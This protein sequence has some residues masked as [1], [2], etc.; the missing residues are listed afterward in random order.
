MNK[1]HPSAKKSEEI[2]H[3]IDKIPSRFGRLMTLVVT[4]III[5]AIGLGWFISYPDIS[6][7][8]IS[9]NANT[10]KIN[11]VSNSSGKLKL[12]KPNQFEVQ[13]GSVVGFIENSAELSNI[14]LVDSILEDFDGTY[15]TICIVRKALPSKVSL[16]EL[17]PRYHTFI[18]S[19]QEYINYYTEGFYTKQEKTMLAMLG[20]QNLSLGLAQRR[21]A[22]TK[23]SLNISKR[24][25]SRDSILYKKSLTSITDFDR[26]RQNYLSDENVNQST[27]NEI[28]NVRQQIFNT[29]QQLQEIA[30]LK[31]ESEKKLF[32]ELSYA[33]NELNDNIKEWKTKYLFISPISGRLQYLKFLVD[34]RFILQGEEIFAI[35]P[36]EDEIFGEVTLPATGAGKVTVGQEVIIKLDN[37]PYYEYGS[38]KGIV[39]NISLVSNISENSLD[40][41]ESYLLNVTLPDG[42][43]T[44]YGK[45]LDFK[46]EI[47]GTAD[48][49]TR[50]RRLIQRM[51]DSVRYLA[52]K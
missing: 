5:F 4:G 20:E 39:K 34:N 48:V 6:T 49:V 13:E 17:N 3:I 16:G 26:S 15:N 44:N 19:L 11:L 32:L 14:L 22:T 12:L 50:D 51:F 25:H 42:L 52:N 40:K 21:A 47:K 7:G 29:T 2:Q 28:N 35:V 8:D 23:E 37:Y 36:Q 9:V 43:V 18:N 33:Y 46:H 10:A 27:E 1:I 41:S 30:I 31:R 45:K 24:N 38:I